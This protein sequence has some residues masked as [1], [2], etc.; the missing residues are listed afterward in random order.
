MQITLSH[1]DDFEIE[2]T[3]NSMVS[4]YRTTGSLTTP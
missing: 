2:L 1:S 4:D 3:A